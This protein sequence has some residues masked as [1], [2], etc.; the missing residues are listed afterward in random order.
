LLL[1][2]ALPALLLTPSPAHADDSTAYTFWVGYFAGSGNLLKWKDATGAISYG[3][4][5]LAA[6]GSW[7]SGTTHVSLTEV[8]TGANIE[9]RLGHFGPTTECGQTDPSGVDANRHWTSTVVWYYNTDNM[10]GTTS[11]QR[12]QC[13]VHEFGHAL[14]LDHTNRNV[15]SLVQMMSS[16]GVNFWT[17]GYQDPRLGD[18]NGVNH[19]Y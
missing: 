5:A 6:A 4:S 14:G 12:K 19:L 15:C 3:N 9:V 10:N 8:T 7:S 1:A 11:T 18:L 16:S 13:G 17:C 2:A